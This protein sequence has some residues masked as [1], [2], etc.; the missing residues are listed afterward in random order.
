MKVSGFAIARNVIKAD[1]PIGESLKSI[2]PLCD[3]I[4]V[5]KDYR[6]AQGDGV[7]LQRFY[8]SREG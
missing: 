2:A 5:A 6:R 1:Y 7:G 8:F 4:V 3:E